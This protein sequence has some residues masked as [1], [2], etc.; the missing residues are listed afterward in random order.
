QRMAE[1]GDISQEQADKAAKSPLGLK[2]SKPKN[3]CITAVRGAGFFCDYVHEVFL[4]DPVFGKTR[5]ERAKVW[6]RG[7][8]TI[9]TTLDPQAQEAVQ[10]SVKDHVYQKD[11]VATAATIGQPGTGKDLAMGQSR[12]YGNEAK[13]NETML[14]LSVDA[15][16]GGGAGFQPGSTFKPIVAAAAL[17]GGMPATKVYA[18]PYEMEYP[19]PVQACDGKIWNEKGVTLTNENETEVGPYDMKEATAKSVNTYFIEM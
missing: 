19:S 4:N 14:N 3:G 15:S 1:V 10:Q 11:E 12:P 5:E 2:V 9:K 17:E 13:K 16:H 7:G 8:L 6:N 18:S